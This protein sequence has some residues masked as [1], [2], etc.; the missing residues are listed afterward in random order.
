MTKGKQIVA[1]LKGRP[2]LTNEEIAALVGTTKRSVSTI[3]CLWKRDGDGWL[4]AHRQA[5]RDYRATPE[6]RQASR[7]A[8]RKAHRNRL[9]GL[10]VSRIKPQKEAVG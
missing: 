7:Q 2:D 9:E 1:L 8:N 5:S 4:K 3:R 6:G 10:D